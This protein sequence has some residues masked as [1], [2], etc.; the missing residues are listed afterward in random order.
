MF[1]ANVVNQRGMALEL[2]TVLPV[3]PSIKLP[4]KAYPTLAVMDAA[5]K[6]STL[7]S[8]EQKQFLL[9]NANKVGNWVDQVITGVQSPSAVAPKIQAL[10]D[11]MPTMGS[12]P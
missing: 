4:I 11:A 1:T 8:L 7:T 3:N 6:N 5:I 2:G 9:Q 12:H 10:F